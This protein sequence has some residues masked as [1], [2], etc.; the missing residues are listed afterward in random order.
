MDMYVTLTAEEI[1]I[2][3]TELRTK[4]SYYNGEYDLIKHQ[5]ERWQISGMH[6]ARSVKDDYVKTMNH[7]SEQ[8][9]KLDRL[10]AK[11]GV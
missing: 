1:D 5:L 7:Y 11:L 8:V 4:R 10:I 2:I 9:S 6:V 3:V